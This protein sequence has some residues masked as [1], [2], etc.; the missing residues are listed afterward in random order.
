M[1]IL[2]ILLSYEVVKRLKN[3]KEDYDTKKQDGGY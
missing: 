1:F 2:M 3:S